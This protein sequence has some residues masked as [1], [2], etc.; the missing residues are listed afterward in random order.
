V[1]RPSLG[2]LLIVFALAVGGAV[3][4]GPAAQISGAAVRVMVAPEQRSDIKVEVVKQNG[5]LPLKVWTFAG[6]THVD[7][8]LGRRFRSCRLRSGAPGAVIDGLGEVGYDGL[9]LILLRTPL[10]ARIFADAGA[11]GSTAGADSLEFSNAGCG[12]WRL[13][14]VR[15]RLKVS[16]AG[17]GVARAAGAASTELYAVD[18]G[19]V[20]SGPIE[21]P[22]MAMNF[23]AGQI[24]VDSA[25]DQLIARTAGAG[26]VHV[27]A[28]HVALLKA[29][30]AGAGAVT[31][32]G[33]ADSLDASVVG[34][35]AI[36][37]GRVTGPIKKQVI[38]S[39]SVRVAAVGAAPAASAPLTGQSSTSINRPPSGAGQD[40]APIDSAP[41]TGRPA[42]RNAP[43]GVPAPFRVYRC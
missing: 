2:A 6:R 7:G 22:V 33:V 42:R 12:L 5:R 15:G 40:S 43:K 36:E 28:G 20:F 17:A 4:A 13:G 8:G 41:K 24:E 14:P 37:V 27:L 26:V 39:G 23:G 25:S 29:Q 34:S 35:G 18:A 11:F 21:G 30:V 19:S 3:T 31:F 1:S 16:Q 32:D 9:P 10:N 38:G